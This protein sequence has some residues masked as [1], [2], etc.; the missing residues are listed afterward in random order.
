VEIARV[1]VDAEPV[2]LDSLDEGQ[3][4]FGG[5]G[6]AAVVLQ[7]QIDAILARVVAR[8]LDLLDAAGAGLLLAVSLGEVAGEDGT[9]L[10]PR[11]AVCSTHV[12]TISCCSFSLAGSVRQKLLPTA[13]PLTSS[14]RR[15]QRPLSEAR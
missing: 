10:P 12:L 14:P 13:V 11:R 1:E 2:V 4:L 7:R 9:V 3:D 15:V 5:A 8:L 6:D